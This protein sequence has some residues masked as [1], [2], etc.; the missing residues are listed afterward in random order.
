MRH[1]LAHEG[2]LYRGFGS[3]HWSLICLF[4]GE[5]CEIARRRLSV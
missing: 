3:G 2:Q 1:P 4:F 5:F